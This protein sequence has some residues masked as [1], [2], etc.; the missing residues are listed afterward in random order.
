MNSRFLNP[1]CNRNNMYRRDGKVF[2]RSSLNMKLH[3]QKFQIKVKRVNFEAFAAVMVQI[4]L[5]GV[6][7]PRCLVC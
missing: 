4:V 7:K 5:F 1:N 3:R 6:V 2:L